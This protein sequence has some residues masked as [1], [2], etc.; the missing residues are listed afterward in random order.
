[1][2]TAAVAV[3]AIATGV[4]RFVQWGL[5]RLRKARL[6][7]RLRALELQ[8]RLPESQLRLIID[9]M[10]AAMNKGLLGDESDESQ[11]D[12]FSEVKMLPAHITI[13]PSGDEAGDFVTVDLGGKG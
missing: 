4:L 11:S 8:F 6:P 7:K 2:A 13:L 12:V 3:I 1:M 10:E 5:V 9:D